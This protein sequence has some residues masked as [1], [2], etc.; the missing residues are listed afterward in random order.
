MRT[1]RLI[2]RWLT[3][4]KRNPECWLENIQESHMQTEFEGEHCGGGD[5]EAFLG[6]EKPGG[7]GFKGWEGKLD[8][9]GRF[10]GEGVL[11]LELEQCL[12][13]SGCKA[14]GLESVEGFWKHG[15]LFGPATLHY[16][17]P[18]PYTELVAFR[19]GKRQG[20]GVV[21]LDKEKQ[22]LA[23]VSRW[24]MGREVGPSWDLSMGHGFDVS[25]HFNLLSETVEE[26]PPTA[27]WGGGVLYNSSLWI[28]P[29]FETT[30]IGSW[31][32]DKEVILEEEE[33]VMVEELDKAEVLIGDD[34]GVKEASSEEFQGW[35]RLTQIQAVQC[36]GGSLQV[37]T[38][39]TEGGIHKYERPTSTSIGLRPNQEDPYERRMVKVGPSRLGGEGLHMRIAAPAPGTLLAY[40]S[41]ILVPVD[42]L[43]KAFEDELGATVTSLQQ[44]DSR[45]ATY[46]ERKSY[47]VA[48]DKETDIDIPPELRDTKSYNATLGHKVN[49]WPLPN[50]YIGWGIHPRFGRV[51][52]IVSL[53]PLQNGEEVPV[54]QNNTV[55]TLHIQLFKSF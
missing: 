26:L 2:R 3:R 33:G 15:F 9:E 6:G 32:K 19:R 24:E 42:S 12:G 37:L 28:Y 14:D 48:L 20:L 25:K 36:T 41:G 1:G 22:H 16:V 52:A 53:R 8:S 30:L 47:L 40:F 4:V 21:F 43:E 44:N 39:Q 10:H 23:K 18:H 46:L 54:K 27:H 13:Q 49:H 55:S 38:G 5:Q 29:D 17:A 45:L 51:R 34:E 7:A 50:S 11:T 31:G 35:G